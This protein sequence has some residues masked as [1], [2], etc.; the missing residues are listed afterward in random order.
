MTHYVTQ[1]HCPP[2]PPPPQVG[3]VLEECEELRLH[4]ETMDNSIKTAEQDA[5]ASR[6]TILRLV[7]EGKQLQEVREKA[8]MLE[9]E[10]E[11]RKASLLTSEQ[12]KVCLRKELEAAKEEVL[13]LQLELEGKEER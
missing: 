1:Y 5:K 9:S 3:G 2:P 10:V 11:G 6:E 13:G 8:A 12:E 7:S 4:C